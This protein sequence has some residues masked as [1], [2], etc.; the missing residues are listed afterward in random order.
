MAGS[1]VSWRPSAS[2]RPE[3]GSW[4]LARS[5]DWRTTNSAGATCGGPSWSATGSRW[6]WP[7]GC[8]SVLGSATWPR[9][10]VSPSG[11]RGPY[12]PRWSACSNCATAPG[13]RR[14]RPRSEHL[15][16][17]SVTHAEGES[18]PNPVYGDRVRSMATRPQTSSSTTGGRLDTGPVPRQGIFLRCR[19]VRSS[20]SSIDQ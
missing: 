2:S 6:R 16:V 14:R 13:S 8:T 10:G 3:A 18:P 17:G 1:R 15:F 7:W 4:C 11:W 19:R 20:P 12:R 9:R 5:A